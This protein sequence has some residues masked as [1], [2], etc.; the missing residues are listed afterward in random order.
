MDRLEGSHLAVDRDDHRIGVFER[1]HGDV[2]E[3]GAGVDDD[4]VVRLAGRLED[5]IDLVALDERRKLGRSSGGQDVETR[6]VARRVGPEQFRLPRRL[7][8]PSDI[9]KRLLD[10]QVEMRGDRAEL[11]RQVDEERPVRPSLG[12][13]DRHVDGDRRRAD[14]ALRGE[15][16]DHPARL[17]LS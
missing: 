1:A 7:V 6:L 3:V 13:G 14:A 11:S 4:R 17:L 16:G 2:V 10:G 8:V 5:Q 12:H 9:G 15:A